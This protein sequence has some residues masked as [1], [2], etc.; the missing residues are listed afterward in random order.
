MIQGAAFLNMQYS[1]RVLMC[2]GAT[3][4]IEANATRTHLVEA[5]FQ[6]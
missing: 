5:R 4:E 3:L 6:R 2:M 1:G